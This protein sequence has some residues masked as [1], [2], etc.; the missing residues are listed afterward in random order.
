MNNEKNK[1]EQKEIEKFETR[2]F[3]YSNEV[4]FE[5]DVE[6]SNPEAAVTEI[7]DF[8]DL[9]KLAIKDLTE[10]REGFVKKVENPKEKKDK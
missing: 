6:V 1:D 2:K 9:M 7:T 10:L 8:I 5:F 3:R 4:T